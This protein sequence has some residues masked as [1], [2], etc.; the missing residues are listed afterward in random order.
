MKFLTRRLFNAAVVVGALCGTAA[1]Q[2]VRKLE[3]SIR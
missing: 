3:R 2:G 1:A